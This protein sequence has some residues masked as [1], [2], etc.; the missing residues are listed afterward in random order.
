[1]T[2]RTDTA[3][4]NTFTHTVEELLGWNRAGWYAHRDIL[5]YQDGTRGGLHWVPTNRVLTPLEQRAAA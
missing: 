1:M 4:T 5:S 3:P 2:T